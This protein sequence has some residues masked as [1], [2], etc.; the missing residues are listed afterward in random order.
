MDRDSSDDAPQQ[1]VGFRTNAEWD[2]LVADASDRLAALEQ[3]GDEQARA[4]VYDALDSLEAIHGEALT[5]LVRLFKNGVLETVV[6]DPAIRTLMGMYGLLPPQEPGCRKVWDF[7]PRDQEKEPVAASAPQ[8]PPHWVP[9]RLPDPP[10]EGEAMQCEMEEGAYLLARAEGRWFAIAAFCPVH[11]ASMREGRIEGI[12]WQ[13]PHGPACSYD[14]RDGRRLG[15]GPQL[16]CRPVR[17]E[18]SG[19]ILIGFGMPFE[20]NLPA[21]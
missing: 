3:I 10:R 1:L 5:R 2:A 7:L 9:A 20:P 6:T 12:S 14:L 11:G 21:F 13:C 4:A 16:D 19:R 17:V 8:P 15:G 18:E